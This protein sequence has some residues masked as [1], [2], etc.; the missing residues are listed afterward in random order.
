M[1]LQECID[2]WNSQPDADTHWDRLDCD[3]KLE[4]VLR[5][6][7][8]PEKL[9]VCTVDGTDDP[10]FDCVLDGT[11]IWVKPD[12]TVAMRMDYKKPEDCPY[13]RCDE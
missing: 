1:N 3:E 9:Y 12:C 4:W 10:I 8:A 11:G 6:V 5:C 2:K 13:W 7:N